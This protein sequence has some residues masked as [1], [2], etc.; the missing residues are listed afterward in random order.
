VTI[1]S[2]GDQYQNSVGLLLRGEGLNNGTVFADNGPLAKEITRIG[3]TVTSTAQSKFGGSSLYFDGNN[4]GLEVGSAFDATLAGFQAGD[5]TIETWFRSSMTAR[6]VLMS[7]YR[8]VSTP[9]G[10]I[11]QFNRDAG[12]GPI[13]GSFVVG[14]GD[15]AL[16]TTDGGLWSA[17]TWHHLALVRSGSTLSFFVDGVSRASTTNTTD[18]SDGERTTIGCLRFSSNG[19]I[20]LPYT[21]YLDDFRITKA[22]RYTANFTPPTSTYATGAYTPPQVLPVVFS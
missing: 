2:I 14:Y 21:G 13:F 9:T 8:A 5:F 1:P 16:L 3:S 4:S 7:A 19:V 11:I 17:N 6:G 12:S 10:I 22:A 20:L 15:T 18:M